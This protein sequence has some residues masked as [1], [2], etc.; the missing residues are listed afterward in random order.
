MT[1]IGLWVGWCIGLGAVLGLA[2][3][4]GETAAREVGAQGRWSW[5]GAMVLTVIV[6]LLSWLGLRDWVAGI[7]ALPGGVAF[8]LPALQ[9]GGAEEVG[10]VSARFDVEALLLGGWLLLSALVGWRLAG[11]FLRLRRERGEWRAAHVGGVPVLVTR[12][13]GPAVFGLGRATILLPEWSLSLDRDLRSVMLLH[14]AEHVRARDPLLLAAGLVLV[15]AMPWNPAVWWQLRR[16][17][18]AI[19]MD[20][21]ARVLRG[22]G[23]ARRYGALL[24]EVGRR[25]LPAYPVLALTEPVSFLERRIRQFTRRTR[26]GAARRA[27]GL[28][29]VAAS[30][31]VV[32]VC[33]RDPLSPTPRPVGEELAVSTGQPQFTPYTQR[34]VLRNVAQVQALLRRNYPPLL[35]D[36]GIGG[37]ANVWLFINREGMVE[38]VRLDRSSGHDALDQ[39]ALRVAAGMEFSPAENRGRPTAVWVNVPVGFSARGEAVLEPHVVNSSERIADR[40]RSPAPATDGPTFTPMTVRP[41]LANAAEVQQALRREYPPMLRDAG[42]GGRALLWFHIDATGSVVDVRLNEGSGFEALDEAAQRVARTMRFTPAYNR[43]EPVAVWV[44]IPITFSSN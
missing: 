6:P 33:T 14:E 37:V 15:V 22:G 29:T 27:V 39:A 4:L 12:D 17:R 2:A 19:E 42:I 28:A 13:V 30:L 35:R 38:S 41:T 43:D 44:A 20:C 16:M 10:V 3:R 34:P 21:D 23:D 7:P 5:F 24:L 25:R 36:A 1:G 8:V 18:M 32:A 26:P 40:P 31:A 11:M 9:V